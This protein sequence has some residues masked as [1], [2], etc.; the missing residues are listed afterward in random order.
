MLVE[1]LRRL[2]VKALDGRFLDGAVHAFDLAVRPRMGGLGQAVFHALF[3]TDAVKAVPAGQELLR[4]RGELHPIVGQDDVDFIGQFVQHPAQEFGGHH[5]LGPR[6][7]FSEGHLAGAVD[8]HEEVL[9]ALF[10]LGLRKID[11]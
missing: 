6:V 1:F 4:L 11:V 10:G 9:L 8:G 7:Q 5:A 3:P 2:V